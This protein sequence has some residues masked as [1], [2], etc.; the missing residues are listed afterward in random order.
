[1]IIQSPVHIYTSREMELVRVQHHNRATSIT[2]KGE[3]ERVDENFLVHGT[4]TRCMNGSRSRWPIQ[5]LGRV[6]CLGGLGKSPVPLHPVEV[7]V[8]GEK[9]NHTRFV[10]CSVVKWDDMTLRLA[11][12]ICLDRAWDTRWR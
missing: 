12:Q 2:E 1:M 7:V 11:A 9:G 3:R 5:L 4:Y 6:V 10:L 8:I